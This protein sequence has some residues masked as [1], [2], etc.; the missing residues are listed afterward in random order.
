MKQQGIVEQV[1]SEVRIRLEYSNEDYKALEVKDISSNYVY[2][3]ELYSMI[4][5]FQGLI[6]CIDAVI[7]F[8][9]SVNTF[10]WLVVVTMLPKKIF[11]K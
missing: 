5:S 9:L 11:Q 4:F 3:D 6:T 10:C 7:R 8:V 1:K 2:N